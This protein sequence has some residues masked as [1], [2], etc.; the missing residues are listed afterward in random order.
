MSAQRTS[1]MN[2]RDHEWTA[3]HR[4]KRR[5]VTPRG[6]SVKVDRAESGNAT[7]TRAADHSETQSKQGAM[8]HSPIEVQESRVES[9][10]SQPADS[11]RRFTDSS[12]RYIGA[13]PVAAAQALAP[14]SSAFV[15]A[16][17][18]TD[19]APARTRSIV[20]ST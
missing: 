18:I 9:D 11:S 2:V 4:R 6:G 3:A 16:S 17:I 15:R 12:R 20:A 13:A 10:L 5:N 14:S 8:G 19:S 1:M 7:R